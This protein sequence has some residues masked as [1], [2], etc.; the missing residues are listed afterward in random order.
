MAQKFVKVLLLIFVAICFTSFIILLNFNSLLYN[1]DFVNNLLENK[2]AV[3]PTNKLINYFQNTDDL[4]EVFQDQREINH[5]KDVKST[6]N[7]YTVVLFVLFLICLS[8]VLL[9][10]KQNIRKMMKLGCIFVFIISIF[11][12]VLPFTPLFQIF[13]Q[14]LF[15]SGTWLFPQNSVLIQFYPLTF[16]QYFVKNILLSSVITAIFVLL[17]ISI[18]KHIS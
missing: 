10:K 17:G 15:S 8:Y 2:D 14:V 9:S 12:I 6:I 1:S 7:F 5:L 4:P 18:S 16:F 11:M 3:E 13:H